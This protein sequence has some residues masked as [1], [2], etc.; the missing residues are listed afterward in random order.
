[1]QIPEKGVPELLLANELAAQLSASGSCVV[2]Y[3]TAEMQ[4]FSNAHRPDLVYTPASGPY[5]GQT[6]FIEVKTALSILSWNI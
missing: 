4:P 1:M 2:E 6:V 5:S 3:A